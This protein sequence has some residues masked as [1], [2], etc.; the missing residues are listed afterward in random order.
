VEGTEAGFVA[1]TGHF[2]FSDETECG[3]GPSESSD[4]VSCG[5]DGTVVMLNVTVDG[6]QI[7]LTHKLPVKA[8]D[9]HITAICHAG[10]E[11]RAGFYTAD[12]CSH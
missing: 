1:L 4:I 3:M 2:R 5:H 9:E 7:A 8:E 11:L 6:N 12:V 10:S